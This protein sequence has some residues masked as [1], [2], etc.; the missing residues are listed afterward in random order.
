ME[1]T[2]HPAADAAVPVTDDTAA[3]WNPTAAVLW[4][5]LFSPAL[6]AWLLM[7]NW[8]RLG[9]RVKARQARFWFV[10]LLAIQVAN[11]IVA[12]V[13]VLLEREVGL[14]WWASV[15]TWGVWVVGS[16][17]PQISHVEDGHGEEYPRRSSAAP[18]L[19]AVAAHLALP[20][21]AGI[22]AGIHALTVA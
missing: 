7:R 1:T 20:V 14:P 19:I 18:L 10:G 5:L 3:L 12:T 8:E 6:G 13:G 22:A 2:L 21:L 17:Y 9:E 4:S 16:A 11:A 15:L